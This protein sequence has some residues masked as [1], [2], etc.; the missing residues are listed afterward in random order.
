VSWA[1]V[2]E[3]PGALTI[4]GGLVTLSG[5]ALAGV[6]SLP[7]LETWRPGAAAQHSGSSQLVGLT[8]PAAPAAPVS[9]PDA[10]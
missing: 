6:R 10:V 7:A 3:V 8:P 4:A 1:W 9:A 5:V 2:G